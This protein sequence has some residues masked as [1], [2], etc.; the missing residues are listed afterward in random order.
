VYWPSVL[1]SKPCKKVPTAD[2]SAHP[3]LRMAGLTASALP[4]VRAQSLVVL[5]KK[6]Q[7]VALARALVTDPNLMLDE[8]LSAFDAGTWLV[9]RSE[10]GHHLHHYASRTMV[11]TYAPLNSIVLASQLV[12]VESGRFVQDAFPFRSNLIKGIPVHLS[13][14][15][16]S[17]TRI[18]NFRLPKSACEL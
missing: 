16:G 1:A 13:R 18:C 2:G 17:E 6:A 15:G 7:R 12:T 3:R 10:L 5:G 11:V 9:V 4:P 8:P 14:M